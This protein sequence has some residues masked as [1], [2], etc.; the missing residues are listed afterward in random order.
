MK[1]RNVIILKKQ[2][3]EFVFSFLFNKV[4]VNGNDKQIKVFLEFLKEKNTFDSTYINDTVM[5]YFKRYRTSVYF[6]FRSFL[7][8]VSNSIFFFTEENIEKFV[9]YE[10]AH[11]F[12]SHNLD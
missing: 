10:E 4:F 7:E 5:S 8:D 3:S 2:M 11:N 12:I 6:K 1:D 9:N